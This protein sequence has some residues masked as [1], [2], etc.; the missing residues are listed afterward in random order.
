MVF[1]ESAFASTT[2]CSLFF[3]FAFSCER[4]IFQQGVGQRV[5]VFCGF[6]D[7]FFSC[8]VSLLS[9]CNSGTSCIFF[10][11]AITHFY[12]VVSGEPVHTYISQ[13]RYQ[14]KSEGENT[15]KSRHTVASPRK[16]GRASWLGRA[17]CYER[18]QDP[19]PHQKFCL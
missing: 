13:Y 15:K 3:P 6:L 12:S 7:L 10:F 9:I 11:G 16:H 18:D 8:Q 14:T 19:S 17:V 5:S 4:G 1:V 2:A